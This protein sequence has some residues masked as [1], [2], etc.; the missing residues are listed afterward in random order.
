[1]LTGRQQEILHFIEQEHARQGLFPTLREI[2]KHFGFASPF[3][4]T[5]HLQALVKKGAL[6]RVCPSTPRLRPMSTSRSIPPHCGCPG[7]LLYSL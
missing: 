7:M 3:A 1:M 6:Q 4:V 2:Q 5:R